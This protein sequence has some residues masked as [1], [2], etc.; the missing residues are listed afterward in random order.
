LEKKFQER[1]ASLQKSYDAKR[2]D[3]EQQAASLAK[4]KAEFLL[5]NADNFLKGREGYNK[6]NYD[7]AVQALNTVDKKDFHWSLAQDD[8][9]RIAKEA[10]YREAVRLYRGGQAARALETLRNARTSKAADLQKRIVQVQGKYEEL[11]ALHQRKAYDP[12]IAAGDEWLPKLD[13]QFDSWY[14][15]KTA[16]ML[17]AARDEKVAQ[18]LARLEELAAKEQYEEYMKRDKEF[19]Q[20][21]NQG[22]YPDAYQK[23]VQLN[24]RVVAEM[25][26]RAKKWLT[27][28][29]TLSET[30]QKEPIGPKERTGSDAQAMQ[31]FVAKAKLLEQIFQRADKARQAVELLPQ[32]E[33]ADI[34]D[35][36]ERVRGEVV[37]QSEK[38]FDIRR[39]YN[40][41]GNFDMARQ[42]KQK[43]LSLPEVPGNQWQETIKAEKEARP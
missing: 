12:L 17:K 36:Y 22:A 27:E 2:A 35:V 4:E 33:K 5:Q 11:L 9:D 10:D 6:G 29:Q 8:L 15:E 32:K 31:A 43:I 7:V 14:V 18:A 16:A 28:A 24:E 20:A 30:Y 26:T 42:A 40:N 21:V 41:M 13:R 23:A 25:K 3:L 34:L 37:G 19:R 38:L 39:T 1:E